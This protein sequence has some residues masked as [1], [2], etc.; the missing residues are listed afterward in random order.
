MDMISAAG[1]ARYSTNNQTENSIAYQ[2][3]EITGYCAAHNIRLT[4]TFIDE[5][6]SGTN[7]NRDGFQDMLRAAKNK[8]FNNI[9]IYDVTRGSRD[10]ADWF[11]FRKMMSELGINV[12]SCHQKLGDPLNP[13]DFLTEFITVGLGQHQVL[14]TR[15][16]SIDGSSA[17]ARKGLFLGGTPPYGY[18]IVNQEYKIVPSE[19][20]IVREAFRLYYEGYSYSY[21]M[22]E[23]KIGDIRGRKG[24]YM[25]K[26]SLYYMFKNPR[27]A[28]VY[29]WNE[30]T[31]QIMRKYVGRKPNNRKIELEGIIPAIV[32]V[33][34]WKGV[35]R[36]MESNK[37]RTYTPKRKRT[38]FL[39]GI[40]KCGICGENYIAHAST[41]KGK[42]YKY[43]VCSNRYGKSNVLD[44]CKSNPV[45][46]DEL[47]NFVI[48]AVKNCLL[49]H[50]DFK[51][52]A[53]KI[54]ERFKELN[55]KNNTKTVEIKKELTSIKNK[56][57]NGIN[58][59]LEG[60]DSEELHEQLKTLKLKQ[61]YLEGCLKNAQNTRF[62]DVDALAEALRNDVEN[63]EHENEEKIRNCIRNH[64]PYIIA[65]EDGSFTVA[66]GYIL[67]GQESAA[68]EKLPSQMRKELYI[69]WQGQ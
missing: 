65:N 49:E 21:I 16:K 29:I 28:G 46:C 13:N 19:A 24:S 62:I 50:T 60:L 51:A 3:H 35:Q 41:S 52:L 32:S 56:I 10:I 12:I 54:A 39:S 23:L 27:Y 63:L 7:T 26:N 45:R 64:V 38:F 48:E 42:E 59:V 8:E 18:E 44:R 22:K 1:Y 68:K 36:R 61:E 67:P 20:R 47:D 14:E 17:A 55:T 58:A 37:K 30:Y 34:I 6:K 69:A 53:N 40:I 2:M 11:Y 33:E 9:I 25:N 31:Y 66:V 15:Q 57:Q 5:G 43:Y 4:H